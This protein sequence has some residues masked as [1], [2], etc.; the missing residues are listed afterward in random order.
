MVVEEAPG[1]NLKPPL[2]PEPQASCSHQIPAT[3]PPTRHTCCILICQQPAPSQ[4]EQ[5]LGKAL[6]N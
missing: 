1:A 6:Q 5:M 3:F 2:C 4:A